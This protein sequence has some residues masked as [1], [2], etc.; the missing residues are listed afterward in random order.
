MKVI[1][2]YFGILLA[3]IKTLDEFDDVG[4]RTPVRALKKPYF[5]KACEDN[6]I[7]R[8]KEIISYFSM[9]I[10]LIKTMDEIDDEGSG[11]TLRALKPYFFNVVNTIV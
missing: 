10:G 7:L 5:E 11:T 3:L 9:L 8:V 2:S 1:I 6:N 4:S